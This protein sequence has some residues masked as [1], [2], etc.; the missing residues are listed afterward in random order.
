MEEQTELMTVDNIYNRVYVIRGQQVM[1]DCDLAEIYGYEV[2]RLN[3]QV[4]RNIARFPEDF[5]FQLSR[6]ETEFVKSQIATSRNNN[7]FEGQEGGR[8]KLPYAFTEQGIYMLATVLRGEL[9]E[10]QSIFIMRVFREMRHYIKQNQQFVTQ[11]ELCL[12]TA[13]VSDTSVQVAS[14]SDRQKKTEQDVHNIQKR[15]D[16]LNENFVSEKD[17]KN[18]VIYKCQKFEAD[19]AYIDIYQQANASIYVV[20][21]YMNTK[22]L[23]L[24]SQKKAGVEVILFTENGHGRNGFLTPAVVKDFIDQYPPLR[25]KS[26][27]ECHDRLIVLDYGLPT[28]QAYHCGASSKD[29]GKKLC[30]INKIE[31]TA[32]VHPI[33]E[34]LLLGED[35]II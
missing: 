16:L 14:L 28:E 4:K 6:E 12:V 24:L 32:M 13:K 33:M 22:T 2:K 8:R 15:I 31:N 7:F 9:A 19:A 10:Q 34:R 25:I 11:S 18:F 20:D 3:E 1:L 27:P 23:Q 5:M 30:A 26:N 21:D 17:F 35:K 29:A